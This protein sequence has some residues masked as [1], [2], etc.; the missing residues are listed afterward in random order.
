METLLRISEED[1]YYPF[2]IRYE[3]N[4][5]IIYWPDFNSAAYGTEPRFIF[6]VGYWTR[7]K[8]NKI[9]ER[10]ISADDVRACVPFR[11]CGNFY[12]QYIAFNI[13]TTQSELYVA[14]HPLDENNE[15]D[16]NL[17]S[18]GSALILNSQN[19]D[20]FRVDLVGVTGE[21]F[22]NGAFVLQMNQ[23]SVANLKK[24]I[25]DHYTSGTA[26]INLTYELALVDADNIYWRY[27]SANN[28]EPVISGQNI[29]IPITS[30]WQ[31]TTH[32]K[33]VDNLK[34]IGIIN[35]EIKD[36][37]SAEVF[38]IDFKTPARSLTQDLYAEILA[39]Y[40]ALPNITLTSS[41][42]IQKPRIINKTIQQVVEMTSVSDSKAN[43]IQPVFFRVRDLAQI[44]VHPEV[45]ENI[46]INLDAY[47]SQV[48]RFYIKLE[49]VS[50]PEIGRT[51]SGIIFKIKGNLLPGELTSGT[52]YVLDEDANLITTGK[53]KYDY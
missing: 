21:S 38:N 36:S 26:T 7:S 14:L 29:Y 2:L 53:Y 41:M 8:Y 51:E 39:A 16:I 10:T 5:I 49:G 47:K 1:R 40:K 30:S 19:S 9:L 24:Y 11:Y 31:H 44:I 6:E 18:C 33:Y 34:L 17:T 45:T 3:N 23:A 27:T 46:C 13:T 48:D 25:T 32:D 22:T 42:N 35:A 20:Q 4:R 28:E 37:K 12:R 52:Y 15:P 43:I 50:F